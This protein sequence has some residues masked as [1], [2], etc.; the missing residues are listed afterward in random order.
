MTTLLL[1][2][3]LLVAGDPC[4]CGGCIVGHVQVVGRCSACERGIP[5]ASDKLCQACA[6]AKKACKHCAKVLG[7]RHV[8]IGTA[9]LVDKQPRADLEYV[10]CTRE[11]GKTQG[12]YRNRTVPQE[13]KAG[14]RA[15]FVTSEGAKGDHHLQSFVTIGPRERDLEVTGESDK[16]VR[17]RIGFVVGPEVAPKDGKYRIVLP[18]IPDHH[19]EVFSSDK[20]LSRHRLWDGRW[21]QD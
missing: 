13:Y 10:V 17:W 18:S 16:P 9:A 5:S 20:V 2:G 15:L 1:L 14:V 11:D 4:T 19:I 7:I 6:D 3:A 8:F 12:V 21:I